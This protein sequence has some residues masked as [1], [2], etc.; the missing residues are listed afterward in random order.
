VIYLAVI[1]SQ[2]LLR[3]EKREG[4]GG[5]AKGT[6]SYSHYLPCGHWAI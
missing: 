6:Y 3:E 2:L 5:H 4:C 1:D